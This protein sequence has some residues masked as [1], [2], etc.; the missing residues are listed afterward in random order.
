M[1]RSRGIVLGC[2]LALA[3]PHVARAQLR[4][5]NHNITNYSSGRVAQF[6]AIDYGVF[7]GRSMSPDVL[8]V[9]EM[10]SAAG[11][12]NYLAILNTAPGST[13]DWVAAPFISGP[14]TNSAMFYRPAKVNFV[15]AVVFALGGGAPAPPRDTVRYAWRPIGYVADA[16]TV[17]CYSV[18]MKAQEAGTSDDNRRLLEAQRIRDDAEAL[19]GWHFLMS[20]DTN[21][22]SDTESAYVEL[23]GSQPNNAGRFFD[24]SHSP[25][26]WNNNGGFKFIHTQDPVGAG[27]MDDRHD[28]I[29]LSASLIDGAGLDYIGNAGIAYSTTTWNDPNH[30]YRAWG[31]DGTSFDT[32]LTVTGNQMVGPTIAQA[33]RDAAPG[34]GH[35]PVF[36]DLRVPPHVAS[37][38]ALDFGQVPLNG[39]AQL[40][41][42][43]SNGGNV[44][45]WTVAGIAD[46]HYTLAASAGFGVAP[47]GGTAAPGGGSVTHTVSMDT[48]TPGVMNGTLTLASDD[49]DEP[50]RIIPLVGEVLTPSCQPADA[51]CD[52]TIDPADVPPF[53]GLLLGTAPPCGSCAG[54]MNDDGNRNGDDVQPFVAA[55]IGP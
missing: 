9:Q 48:S 27:G 43:V 19:P 35:L 32:Q 33:L 54:D 39:V 8:I 30:S 7:Q 23:V 16:S 49:P 38:T 3:V 21:I 25:G 44:A 13:G 55:I 10:I 52:T 34:G 26:T 18:H 22:Q 53:V 4:V 51:N 15:S 41:L 31:N 5:A 40:D 11:V 46:L 20:G 45:L 50:A 36:L 1:R 6:Q 17:A 28:Q 47:P 37:E 29:L 2:V 14:D 42:H 12:T 24:P